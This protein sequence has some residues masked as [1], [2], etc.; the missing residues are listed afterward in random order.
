MRMKSFYESG[1]FLH[2]EFRLEITRHISIIE[3]GEPG[4]EPFME[5][6][7]MFIIIVFPGA[8][9]A[10]IY[11]N[12]FKSGH[13]GFL[14]LGLSAFLLN[15]CA[16]GLYE[17]LS[18]G[19]TL[20]PVFYEVDNVWDAVNFSVVILTVIAILAGAIWGVVFSRD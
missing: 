7:L 1:F 17:A 16:Y 19:S 14:R 12:T 6:I 11:D 5:N 9:G 20:P 4:Q 15:V 3:L 8:V 13:T 10:A 2:G 18:T